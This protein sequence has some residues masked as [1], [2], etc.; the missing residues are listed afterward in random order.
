[1]KALFDTSSLLALVRYYLPFD[2]S[3]TLKKKIQSKFESG[4]ILLLDKVLAES[5]YVAQGVILKE[6]EFID[7]KSPLLVKTVDLVPSRK[8]YNFLE[9][10]FCNKD[11]VR[12]KGITDVE[13]ELEKTR[14]LATADAN[15]ILYAL[16]IKENAP[17]IVTEETKS[18]NDS[19]V[20]KKIPENCKSID[21]ACCSLPQFLKDH[22]GISIRF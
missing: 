18:S 11:I 10:S 4:E 7:P 2:D 20:F 3:R 6:L 21:I 17:I 16:S 8:F 1:M 12:L 15:L 19:K 13:F 14:F 22:F 5:K 9:N